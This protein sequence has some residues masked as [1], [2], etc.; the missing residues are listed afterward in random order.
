MVSKADEQAQLNKLCLK[1]IRDFS[2]DTV[3]FKD[4]DS[5]FIWNSLQH[6]KQCNVSDPEQMKGKTDADFFPLDFALR[7]RSDELEIMRT[8]EPKT[9]ISE[10]MIR[11]DGTTL[12]L[13]AS[14]YPFFDENHNIIGTWGI[15]R[16]VTRE[17]LMSKE[18]K[19]TNQNLERLAR[20]DEL[21][22]LYN[23][24]YFFESIEE[25]HKQD[26]DITY[27]II[28]VDID[29]LKVVNDNYGHPCGDLVIDMVASSMRKVVN[30]GKCFRMGGDEFIILLPEAT[31]EA[32]SEVAENLL[33][34]ISDSPVKMG[35]SLRNVTVSL[36]IGVRSKGVDVQE[37]LALA[38][39]KLYKS[40]NNGK[41]QITD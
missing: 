39:R 24:R 41:N 40:K 12:Y 18:L 32:A 6:A 15:S 13:L 34:T 26:E 29:N 30:N 11:D 28:L 17:R 38:D 20:V 3:Y 4:K 21:S 14:K 23:R 22:G 33:K 19:K 35:D 37:V 8:G 16:D 25:L 10:E 5:R 31:R 7:A 36:G 27:A 2:H 9:N 1:T